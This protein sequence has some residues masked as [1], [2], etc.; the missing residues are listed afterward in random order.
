MATPPKRTLHW[1]ERAQAERA[2][3]GWSVAE[4]WRRVLAAGYRGDDDPSLFRRWLKGEHAP[5]EGIVAALARVFGWP[6]EAF[7]EAVAWPPRVDRKT[8][9]RIVSGLG[10][11]AL[12]VVSLLSDPVAVAYL[13]RAAD[14]Y[15]E[16]KRTLAR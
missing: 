9:E 11:D 14:Q 6:V 16:L 3:R 5:R 10:D 7:D 4:L 8:A 2:R 13:A 1:Y 15:L 12:K